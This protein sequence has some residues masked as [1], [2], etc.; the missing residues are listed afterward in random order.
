MPRRFYRAVGDGWTGSRVASCLRVVAGKIAATGR[1]VRHCEN[2]AAV[3]ASL[4]GEHLPGVRSLLPGEFVLVSRAGLTLRAPEGRATRYALVEVVV[5]DVYHLSRLVWDQ[6]RGH[7]LRVLDVGAHVGSFAVAIA[8]RYP[9]ATVTCYEPSPEASAYLRTNILANRLGSRVTINRAAVGAETGVARLLQAESASAE[10][11]LV[12]SMVGL[13][14]RGIVCDVVDFATALATSSGPELV[15]LDCEGMEY[16][17]VLRSDPRLWASV[18]CV[19]LEYHPVPGHSWD[20]IL[21]RFVEFGF[22]CSWHDQSSVLGLGS[23]M[24]LR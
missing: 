15:K 5:D 13:G 19:L 20:E 4:V 18:R 12:P 11:S 21:G 14:A 7:P 2:W 3:L 24:L 1:V 10:A 17:I 23:A 6:E 8:A 22:R 16:D 9:R